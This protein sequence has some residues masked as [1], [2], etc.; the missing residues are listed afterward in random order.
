MKKMI[1]MAVLMTIA[2]TASAM[3]YNEAR[4]EALFLS[5]KMAYE[6]NLSSAQY[7][8]VYEINLD[9]LLCVNHSA[10]LFGIY[11]ERRNADLRFVLTSWQ[12][13]RYMA[14]SYFFRPLSW[15]KSSWVF[16][17]YSHYAAGHLF[18][19]HPKV[20]VSYRGGH[21]RLSS[22]HYAH[23]AVNKPAVNVVNHTVHI[24]KPMAAVGKTTTAGARRTG[25]INSAPVN[26]RNTRGSANIG[27]VSHSNSRSVSAPTSNS[28]S[29]SAATSTRTGT[30]AHGNFGGRR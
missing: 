9:Y 13:D 22:S 5:D 24:G 29:V 1:T 23:R 25:T 26:T 20:Y 8:D 27:S 18:N 6:L 11:W 15:V 19:A 12:Y 17:V 2:I 7:E 21:N 30:S 28:R 3:T 4:H 16:S 14:T 10:D